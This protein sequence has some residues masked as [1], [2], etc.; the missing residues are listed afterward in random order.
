MMDAGS[1]RE[2]AIVLMREALALLDAAHARDVAAHLQMALDVAGR[3][4]PMKPGDELPEDGAGSRPIAADPALV[5]AMGGALALFATLLAR[6][7]VAPVDEIGRL[8]GIYAVATG[9]TERDEGLILGCWAGML[10]DVAQDQNGE[11][12]D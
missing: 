11:A 3:I 5:R 7:G 4:P 12:A 9:E 10:R 2:R 8:L 6:T 1:M